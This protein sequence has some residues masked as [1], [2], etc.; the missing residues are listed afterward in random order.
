MAVTMGGV[1]VHPR[2]KQV[3]VAAAIVSIGEEEE[4]GG[5]KHK[6]LF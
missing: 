6:Q 4:K 3:R 2:E 5:L 1:A